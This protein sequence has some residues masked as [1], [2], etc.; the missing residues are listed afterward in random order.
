MIPNNTPKKVALLPMV[1]PTKKKIFLID[2]FFTPMDHSID[3]DNLSQF[4]IAKILYKE[5]PF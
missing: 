1:N 5:N 2:L 3:I 4:N